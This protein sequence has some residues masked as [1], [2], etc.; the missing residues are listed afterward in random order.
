MDADKVLGV[1]LPANRFIG[2]IPEYLKTADASETLLQKTLKIIDLLDKET[3]HY[4]NLDMPP[5][6]VSTPE[7]DEIL[8]GWAI[9]H[10]RIGFSIEGEGDESSWYAVTDGTV[11]ATNAWGYLNDL[12]SEE[13]LVAF[14]VSYIVGIYR[15]YQQ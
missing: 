1:K 2:N 8:I 13:K 4:Q 6:G 9:P 5:I 11:D 14:L 10:V 7:D 3:Q 12:E 15:K